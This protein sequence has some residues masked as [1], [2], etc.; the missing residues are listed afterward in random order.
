MNF[1]HWNVPPGLLPGR[2]EDRGTQ[3]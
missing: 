1:L 3:P 2:R